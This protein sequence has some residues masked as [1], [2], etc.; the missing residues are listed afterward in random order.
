MSLAEVKFDK[1]VSGDVP[2]GDLRSPG[3]ARRR[4]DRLLAER[5]ERVRRSRRLANR[6]KELNGYLG[7]AADVTTA[8]EQLSDQLFQQLLRVVEEKL[9]I[10]LQEILDQPIRFVAEPDFKRGGAT[11][12]F[13]IDRD[14]CREDV[15]KGQ[16]GSVANILSVGLRMFALTTLDP[17][18]H[19]RVLVLDEQDC[20]LRPDL[21]PKLV[22]IVHDA[23]KA[24]GFQVIMISHHDI[25]VFE[26]FADKIFQFIPTTGGA[27]TVREI[28]APARERDYEQ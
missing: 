15:L 17:N 7:I 20:W 6:F 26:Q 13:S 23:G 22:K 12:S 24:L 19:R 25:A 21:V 5:N 11:V 9:S 14:G 10:A 8:L 4:A 16:G 2:A 3:E 1:D 18:Q 27:V 28:A